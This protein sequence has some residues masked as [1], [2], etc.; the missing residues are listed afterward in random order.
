MVENC[1]TY[2]NNFQVS[3]GN[4]TPPYNNPICH[5]SGGV[6]HNSGWFVCKTDQLIGNYIGL[7]RID[8]EYLMLREIWVYS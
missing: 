6:V 5:D 8:Q 1:Y 2:R 7:Y 4:S 3:V